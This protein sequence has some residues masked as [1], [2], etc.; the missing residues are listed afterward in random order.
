MQPILGATVLLQVHTQLQVQEHDA[1]VGLLPLAVVPEEGR[2]GGREGG[3]GEWEKW[4]RTT[5][6]WEHL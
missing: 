3:S 2:E 5:E 6:G 1:L 4:K